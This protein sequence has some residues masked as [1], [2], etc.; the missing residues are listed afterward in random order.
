MACLALLRHFPTD[1]NAEAR[2]QG[3]TDRP[4][5]AEGRALLQT[6]ALPEPWDRAALIA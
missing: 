1:W 2:L 4:L 6:L 3:R 5:S